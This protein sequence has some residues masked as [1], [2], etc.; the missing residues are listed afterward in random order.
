MKYLKRR[1]SYS[2]PSVPRRPH[3]SLD[4]NMPA[5]TARRTARNQSD[6]NLEPFPSLYSPI[7]RQDDILFSTIQEP[8]NITK[9][10]T[11]EELVRW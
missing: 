11:Y 6:P 10:V 3:L 1:W 9:P 8:F 7:R 5:R 2:I 4:L